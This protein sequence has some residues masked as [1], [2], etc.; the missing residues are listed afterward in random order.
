MRF[1]RMCIMT[2]AVC[3]SALFVFSASALLT[4]CKDASAPQ[5]NAAV[6]AGAPVAEGACQQIENITGSQGL[7][8]L[9]ASLP[10][11]AIIASIV[12]PLIFARA[13]TDAGT[14]KVIPTTNLCATPSELHQGIDAVLTHRRALLLRDAGLE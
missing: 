6:E 14:C 10:E 3:S 1:T 2:V 8:V 9:C 7:E 5:V 12:T 13:A 4:D 11:I